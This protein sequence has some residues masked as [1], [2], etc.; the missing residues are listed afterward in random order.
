[1]ALNARLQEYTGSVLPTHRGMSCI[2]LSILLIYWPAASF[3]ILAQMGLRMSYASDVGHI[4][5]ASHDIVVPIFLSQ[6][7]VQLI[8]EIAREAL[9]K[10]VDTPQVPLRVIGDDSNHQSAYTA[11]IRGVADDDEL[12]PVAWVLDSD[13]MW[14]QIDRRMDE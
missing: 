5:D 11:N 3:D 13:C 6:S 7:C 4:L 2:R 14:Q 10:V 8:N 1:M 12:I 9:C